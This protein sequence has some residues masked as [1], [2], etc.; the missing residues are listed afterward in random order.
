MDTQ[1]LSVGWLGKKDKAVYLNKPLKSS[2]H[3]PVDLMV[4]AA[5]EKW[6]ESPLIFRPAVQFRSLFSES[7]S[8]H[9]MQKVEQIK[10]KY[11]DY[12]KRA[13]SL[14][15]L[16]KQYPE[17]V[18]PYLEV[19]AIDSQ[20]KI[21]LTRLERFGTLKSDLLSQDK[22]LNLKFVKNTTALDVP[23]SLLAVATVNVDGQAVDVTIGAVAFVQEQINLQSLRPLNAPVTLRSGINDE[24]IEGIYKELNN[25]VQ[26]LR[27]QH[28][29][30]QQQ[31][32]ASGLWDSSHTKD[33]Y[34]TKKA[35][36]AFKVFPDAS[37]E[38]S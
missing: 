8:P 34:G 6:Q 30:D 33:D 29:Q 22:P 2:N 21:Y 5:N 14:E 3:S 17:L 9:I 1:N 32:L 25:Y 23:N 15:E 4:K 18:E 7:S 13:R 19:E 20:N 27:E 35:L 37:P 26:S 24:R 16:K 36:L 12:L 28:S 38:T 10:T 11:N 31:S